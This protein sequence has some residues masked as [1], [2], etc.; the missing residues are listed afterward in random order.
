MP[1]TSMGSGDMGFSIGYKMLNSSL[2]NHVDFEL[3]GQKL[4][5]WFCFLYHTY[6]LQ[7]SFFPLSHLTP[8]HFFASEFDI[9]KSMDIALERA[10]TDVLMEEAPE[11]LE[12]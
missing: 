8:R 7:L 5:V 9:V 6:A 3:N 2:V 10:V 11:T 1:S 12:E 4:C